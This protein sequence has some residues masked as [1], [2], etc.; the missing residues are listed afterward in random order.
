MIYVNMLEENLSRREVE[1]L[2][3]L[4]IV[5]RVLNTFRTCSK[6]RMRGSGMGRNI[7]VSGTCDESPARTYHG[8]HDRAS[9]LVKTIGSTDFLGCVDQAHSAWSSVA[10]G[11][12]ANN[13]N[14]TCI[15][16]G[17]VTSLQESNRQS[18]KVRK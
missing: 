13:L 3:A 18:V 1:V 14:H 11:T 4:H 7:F 6:G 9:L 8:S 5:L 10:A 16:H 15:K 2:Y 12:R 17:F